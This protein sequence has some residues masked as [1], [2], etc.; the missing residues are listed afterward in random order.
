[1]IGLELESKQ[2]AIGSTGLLDFHTEIVHRED[3]DKAKLNQEN[4][5][6]GEAAPLAAGTILNF[7]PPVTLE[8]LGSQG[9]EDH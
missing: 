6:E 1:M 2:G 5:K 8:T 7:P 9:R 3:S 4:P